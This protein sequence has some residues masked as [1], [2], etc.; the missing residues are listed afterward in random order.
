MKSKLYFMLFSLLCSGLTLAGVLFIWYPRSVDHLMQSQAREAAAYR[1][2]IEKQQQAQ[3][4][5]VRKNIELQLR[6]K[7]Y[8]FE[9]ALQ[10]RAAQI[11][12]E[13]EIAAAKLCSLDEHAAQDKWA[14]VSK[15]LDQLLNVLGASK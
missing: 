7:N 11:E 1:Q 9:E 5:V 8:E 3:A 14:E 12:M 2:T 10:Q 6:V 4:I 15:K 13:R